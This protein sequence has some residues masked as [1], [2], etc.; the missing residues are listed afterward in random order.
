L[1]KVEGQIDSSKKFS[2]I[3]QSGGKQDI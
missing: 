2:S 1:T 3:I